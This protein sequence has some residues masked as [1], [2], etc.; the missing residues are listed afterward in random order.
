[1]RS[2]DDMEPAEEIRQRFAHAVDTRRREPQV[3]HH[4]HEIAPDLVGQKIERRKLL[5]LAASRHRRVQPRVEP[6]E[7]RDLDRAAVLHH[8]EIPGGEVRHR[9]SRGIHR[10]GVSDQ[11]IQGGCG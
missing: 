9:M 1:M 8:F 7:V 11:W 3:I 4:H 6:R 10:H 2:P 5:R